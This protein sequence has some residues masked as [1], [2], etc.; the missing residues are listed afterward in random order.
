ML[1][2]T[3]SSSKYYL[4]LRTRRPLLTEGF[5]SS[6]SGTGLFT[7]GL[8]GFGFTTLDKVTPRAAEIY[9]AMKEKVAKMEPD[10]SPPGLKEQ[11]EI[12]LERFEPGK[13]SPGC[14]FITVPSF[15][16]GPSKFCFNSSH[17]TM[18]E[19]DRSLPSVRPAGPR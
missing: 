15:M 4:Q 9:Q 19:Y 11:Y 8:V 17:G 2:N 16:S 1:Q 3:W 12:T 7:S 6:A 5:D 18:Q 10:T 13:G 14:E